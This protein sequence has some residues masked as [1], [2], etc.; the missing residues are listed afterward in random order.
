M[1][2]LE[3]AKQTLGPTGADNPQIR[4]AMTV[5]ALANLDLQRTTVLAPSEAGVTPGPGAGAAALTAAG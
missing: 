1:A 5:L 3:R 2:E 4:E